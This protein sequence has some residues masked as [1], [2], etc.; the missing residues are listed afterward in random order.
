M[1]QVA[2]KSD[3]TEGKQCQL[4]VMC[5]VCLVCG[6]VHTRKP[7]YDG[8]SLD[9]KRETTKESGPGRVSADQVQ[10]REKRQTDDAYHFVKE[11]DRWRET[12]AG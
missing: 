9:W 7:Q 4:Q 2:V 3:L 10:D 11:A 6:D 12:A 1:V 8:S 5:H